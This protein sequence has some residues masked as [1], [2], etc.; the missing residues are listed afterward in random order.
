M[1]KEHLRKSSCLSPAG[2]PQA[3]EQKLD[4]QMQEVPNEAE[5]PKIDSSGNI[6]L[7]FSYF[8]AS[9]AFY[10]LINLLFY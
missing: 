9:A 7:L 1:Q 2:V 4:H 10:L 3:P 8:L 6:A 5:E